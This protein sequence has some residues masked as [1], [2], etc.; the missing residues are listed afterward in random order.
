MYKLFQFGN[1]VLNDETKEKLQISKDV[2][3]SLLAQSVYRLATGWTV[4][5][6]NP[7]GGRDFPHLFR[8]APGVHPASCT[9]GTGSFPGVESGQGVTL[10]PHPLLVL[11]SKKRV[12]IYLY[13][14]YGP[15]WPVKRFEPNYTHP[16]QY[17]VLINWIDLAH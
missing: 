14:P 4:R 11:R 13:S 9:M 8:S 5:G 1:S 16:S 6:S 10:T 7:G 3:T 2:T 17:A 12:E 15:S